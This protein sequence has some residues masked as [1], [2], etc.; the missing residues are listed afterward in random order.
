MKLQDASDNT[1]VR[2]FLKMLRHGEGTTDE[3][4]YRRMFG[5]KLF[6]SFADHPRQPQT[7]T[8]RGGK[9]L[10]SSAAGAYQFL[11]RTWDGL[12]KQYGFSDF[13]PQ[14]QDLAA[15][16]LIKG[17]KALDDVIAGRFDAAVQKCNKEWAS[18]PGSP[19]GQPTTTLQKARQLY[20]DAGG[21]F[22][23]A[24][25]PTIAPGAKSALSP[26]PSSPET[27]ML[28]FLAAAL[29]YLFDAVPKLVKSFS[30]DGVSVPARNEQAVTLAMQIAKTALGASNDQAVVDAIKDDPE[31]AAIVRNAIDASW[32][33]ITDA[34]GVA[35]ARKADVAFVAA[36][37]EVWRSPS[38]IISIAL[39]PIVYMLV[40]A[41][42]GLFGQPFSDDVRSAI[43]NGVIGLILGG[44]TGYYFGQTTSR[45]R[46]PP[47]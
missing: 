3:D 35:D 19:Y 36:G 38:F 30:D 27:P 23:S 37:G 41:V 45:N 42:V 12:V 31:A 7:A 26:D 10:T 14:S 32:A 4:G 13:S 44:L 46:T 15:V 9:T 16:A 5:G 22:A 6:D 33:Q 17:R 18:L 39:L 8:F 2:A 29:P 24:T 21:I 11:T 40:G 20:T 43:A 25:Q 34:S 28:P 47:A 1:N